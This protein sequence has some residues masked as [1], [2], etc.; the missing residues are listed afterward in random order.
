MNNIKKLLCLA[1]ICIP[2]MLYA[3]GIKFEEGLTWNQVL[4]KAKTENKY[5]FVDCYA[6]WCGP[7]KY[8]DREVYSQQS[9]GNYFND[10]F[11][12]VKI[13]MDT[14]K[15]DNDFVKR[16][17]AN[18][19]TIKKKYNVGA[20]PTY[21]FFSPDGNVVHREAGAKRPEE[22]IAAATDA[23]D[24]KKQYYTA[25]EKYRRNKLDTAHMKMLARQ[26]KALK[27]N[28]L[29]DKIANDYINRL[30]IDALF[31]QDN[32]R[33]MYDFTKSSKDRGFAL[34]R[35]SAKR[36][37]EVDKQM[38]EKYTNGLVLNIIY[39]EEIA[40]YTSSDNG[41]ADWK[42]INSNLKKYGTLGNEA[43]TRYKPGII[44]KTEIK[45]ALEVNS[46]WNYILPLIQKYKLGVNAELVVGSTVVY[47][48]NELLAVPP[49]QK[50][51]KNLIG[52]ATYYADSFPTLLT[53][54]ALNSWAWVIFV[55][56]TDKDEL[57]KALSWS[58]RS[59]ELQQG[60]QEPEDLDT[61]ANLLYKLGR[62]QE[63][64]EWEEKAVQAD[65]H[66]S[67]KMNVDPQP[68]YEQT[69]QK[70]KKSEKTW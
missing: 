33:F 42:K 55:N 11:I 27:E 29:A 58:K 31:T 44:F 5:I 69:L 43:F 1:I 14:S 63:A 38:Q 17:Y 37:N 25:L 20:F 46:D 56:S 65:N 21:L 10:K 49:I 41:K 16:W 68:V 9:V 12:S 52:A 45:P 34:F 48:V 6:T 18:A 32:I 2:A 13:Q 7:C 67:K 8:M 36:I 64:I 26:A 57:N 22:F 70:M 62:V 50:N 47:Y 51:C 28:E 59:M 60:P 15:T 23:L 3:Q 40:P 19:N 35:D 24:P 4:Q 54:S 66:R 61:Y 53:T 30:S 39:K